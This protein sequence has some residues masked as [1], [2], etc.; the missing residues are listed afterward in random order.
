MDSSWDL[1]YLHSC[2]GQYANSPGLLRNLEKLPISRAAAAQTLLL[3][4]SECL[5][6]GLILN[7]IADFAVVIEIVV[8]LVDPRLSVH[9]IFFV[10]L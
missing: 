7:N 5:D 4:G 6:I 2:Q 3:M 9:Y 10:N 8:V 1:E